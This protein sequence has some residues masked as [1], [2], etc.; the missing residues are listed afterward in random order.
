MTANVGSID[1]LLRIVIGLSLLA[2]VFVWA[3]PM[4]LAIVGAIL[5]LTGLV[6][7]CPAYRLIGINTSS[8]S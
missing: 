7:F 6:S 5:A 2:L 8:R 1:R 4:W 3:Q